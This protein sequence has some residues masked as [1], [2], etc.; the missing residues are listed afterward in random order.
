MTETVREIQA[1]LKARGYALGSSG[2]ARDGIDGEPGDLTFAA[3]LAELVKGVGERLAPPID[4]ITVAVLRAACP[5]R[6]DLDLS[7]WVDPI[8]A[9]CRRFA[10]NT[11]RRIAAFIAQM[12]HES[13]MKPG[14]EESFAYSAQR[15]AEVWPARYALDPKATVKRPNAL[16]VRLAA[17]GAQAIA[18]N[19]YANRM[20]NGNEASGDGWAN[21]GAGPGQLTGLD[22][23]RAFAAAIG[24]SLEAARAYGRTIEGGVMSFAWFW[25]END[26]NRLADSPG[27]SDETQA[28]NG[29][30]TGLNDR[31]RRFDATVAALLAAERVI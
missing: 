25:E 12:A 13:G 17:A 16:A 4:L 20:G 30:Q 1:I 19:V 3:V 26:I 11:I 22:N 23:W 31:K 2:P 21:R 24:M 15:M 27:V 9:A 6:S 8:R 10:I 28:I 14:R 18:N 5:E 29:G 7:P